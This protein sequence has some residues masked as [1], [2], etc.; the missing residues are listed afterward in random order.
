MRDDQILWPLRYRIARKLRRWITSRVLT[1]W[2]WPSALRYSLWGKDWGSPYWKG[3]GEAYRAMAMGPGV[4]PDV[5]AAPF[6]ANQVTDAD[7]VTKGD[8]SVLTGEKLEWQIETYSE[9]LALS[10]GSRFCVPQA[11]SEWATP[12]AQGSPSA[13]F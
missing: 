13:V 1:V 5:A 12:P 3:E 8:R 11:R 6:A 9:Q 4:T 2:N 10:K 7:V